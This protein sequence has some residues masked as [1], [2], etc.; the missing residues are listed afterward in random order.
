[1]RISNSHT[2]DIKDQC[3]MIS[4]RP[5][6]NIQEDDGVHCVLDDS[7][8]TD[9]DR[10]EFVFSDKWEAEHALL[11]EGRFIFE[12]VIWKSNFIQTFKQ[13]APLLKLSGS[14]KVLEMGAAHCWA[15]VLLKSMYPDGYFVA[16]DL[17]P[18]CVRNATKW[19]RLLGAKIDEKWAFNCRDIP[20]QDAQFDV[21]FTFA[22]FHHFGE[23]GNYEAATS[24]MIRILKP[25][26]RIVLLYE[27]SSPHLFYR[28]AFKRV[29]RKRQSDGVDEDVLLCGKLRKVVERLGCSFEAATYP[30]WRYRE[31]VG[32]TL[33]YSLLSMA[34]PL[35]KLFVST[36]NIEIHKPAQTN[37]PMPSPLAVVS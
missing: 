2:F 15:T 30:I 28:S 14:N 23:N 26:G 7:V 18:D 12:A 25:G 10:K 8:L 36:V 6:V 13:V 11:P 19:E 20:F 29:N 9:S 31:S 4:T 37:D 17:I 34:G 22:A 32:S 3:T 33:Y 21:I 35:N 5:G 1:M 16:A 24:E 27:P